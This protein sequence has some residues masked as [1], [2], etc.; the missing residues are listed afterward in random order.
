MFLAS[1]SKMPG[2]STY[3]RNCLA[4]PFVDKFV[5]QTLEIVSQLDRSAM[6]A[7]AK[8]LAD[9]RAR[10]GRRDRPDRVILSR[11]L[12]GAALARWRAGQVLRDDRRLEPF[13]A[14][15]HRHEGAALAVRA[16]LRVNPHLRNVDDSIGRTT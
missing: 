15:A 5:A 4:D 10:G 16:A 7:M 1:L 2:S 6:S 3:R 9:V 11:M 8:G 12:R 14:D 13:L